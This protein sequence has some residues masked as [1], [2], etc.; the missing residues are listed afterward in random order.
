MFTVEDILSN[1][2][3]LYAR[4]AT[5]AA[6]NEAL[7]L[8]T[9]GFFVLCLALGQLFLKIG[10]AHSGVVVSTMT[11]TFTNFAMCGLAWWL[12]GFGLV[13]GSGSGFV[14]ASTKYFALSPGAG[15]SAHDT[16]GLYVW[17]IKMVITL[18]AC[19]A[20]AVGRVSWEA[21]IVVACVVST[22]G[23]IPVVHWVWGPDGWLSPIASGRLGSGLLDGGSSVVIHV[24]GGASAA[25]M[26][27]MVPSKLREV[28]HDKFSVGTGVILM[29]FGWY[30]LLLLSA[31]DTQ[32]VAHAIG[33]LTVGAGCACL[34]SL[35]LS[36][37][38]GWILRHT[39]RCT[40]AGLVS[41]TSAGLYCPM[42]YSLLIG[43]VGAVISTMGHKM[44]E[45]HYLFDPFDAVSSHLLAGIWGVVA[46]ALFVDEDLVK[47]NG[48]EWSGRGTVMGVHLLAVAAVA[49]WAVLWTFVGTKLAR[50]CLGPG[51]YRT[52]DYE[53]H[54]SVYC[55]M[56]CDAK[57][58]MD[59]KVG[60]EDVVSLAIPLPQRTPYLTLY[61]ALR[62]S[63]YLTFV[64]A[65]T[66]V[67]SAKY[68]PDAE[69]TSVPTNHT[70]EELSALLTDALNSVTM[71][72]CDISTLWMLQCSA[73]V[74]LMQMGFCFLEAGGVRS[75]SVISII[76]KNLVD[77]SLGALMWWMTGYAFA[78]G[79]GSGFIGGEEAM[80]ALSPKPADDLFKG[81]AH[82]FLSFT[83]MTASCTIVSGAVAERMNLYAYCLFV[84]VTCGFT[85]PVVVHWG[86]SST[87][88]LSAFSEDR[89]WGNGLLD[90][91]GSGVIHLF[92]G[93][94]AL[95]LAYLIGPR[96]L[97]DN[98]DLFSE[99]GQAIVSPHNKFLQAAGTLL[100]WISWFMFNGGSVVSFSNG[101]SAVAAQ[102]IVST[103]IA[104]CFAGVVGLL[105]SRYFCGFLDI[106]HACN[107]VLVG[108][109][110][111]TS[112]CAYVEIAFSPLIGAVGV[113][114]YFAIHKLRMRLRIDDVVDAGAVHF[115]GGLWGCIATGLFC[116]EEIMEAALER[117]VSG[118]GLFLGGGGTQ[119]GVQLLYCAVVMAWC[120]LWSL[121]VYF[122]CKYTIGA[123]AHIDAEMEGLDI[124]EHKAHSYDYIEKMEKERAIAVDSV[125]LA[126][127]IASSLVSFD[128]ESAEDAINCTDSPHLDA[129]CS[130]FSSLLSNL[131]SY[132]PYIPE[133]LFNNDTDSCDGDNEQQEV[134]PPG[135]G[136]EGKAAIVFTD[137]KG[138]TAS[139]EACPTDMRE[140]LRVH[141][142][143]IRKCI[144]TH[145]G[146]EVKTIGDA[147]M[148]A[149][150]QLADAARF[151]LDVQTGLHSYTKWPSGLES[152]PHCCV[153]SWYGLLV[154]IGMNYG[155]VHSEVNPITGRCDYSGPTVNKASRLEA[156]SEG[157]AVALPKEITTLLEASNV[158][159]SKV[160]IANKK[161][162][163]M[164]GVPGVHKIC[165]VTPVAILSQ[166]SRLGSDVSRSSCGSRQSSIG[167][168]RKQSHA[169]PSAV[170]QSKV[171]QQDMLK[172][173]QCTIG[174][175]W[176]AV[177]TTG[178]RTAEILIQ[179]SSV[180]SRICANMDRTEGCVH[181]V[182]ESRVAVTWN[183]GKRCHLHVQSGIRF[184][185]LCEEQFSSM[186]VALVNGT[187]LH[188]SVGTRD[189]RFVNLFGSAVAVSES[190]LTTA[191]EL[192]TFGL[193]GSMPGEALPTLDSSLA[194]FI[195]P[196]LRW[197]IPSEFNNFDSRQ[198][199]PNTEKHLC[200]YQ[201]MQGAGA[202]MLTLE[203]PGVPQSWQWS[204][205]YREAFYNDNVDVIRENCIDDPLSSVVLA[206]FGGDC[207]LRSVPFWAAVVPKR[208]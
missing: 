17:W 117:E 129:L 158:L 193:L 54:G 199:I 160:H 80:F 57:D 134:P 38:N 14:G 109:V 27:V 202:K 72:Q 141:N 45:K 5:V 8:G 6:D 165:I 127:Q 184:T 24:F 123:R 59:E 122:F 185:A 56:V 186:S 94:S 105:C 30:G 121:G 190:L 53:S 118:Y 119:L 175:V 163:V 12:Y 137:I 120:G 181:G 51:A 144:K 3:V 13:A 11:H 77:C 187:L 98:I 135:A 177:D 68:T 22:F 1:H 67:S 168:G 131:N 43:S 149:F 71:S 32:V 92:G 33:F 182:C 52:N 10:S 159:D 136:I 178:S 29:W 37:G 88:F 58:V 93:T 176:A 18:G 102:A 197:A 65:L 79:K 148:V 96:K 76:F 128:L 64:A 63:L 157:G 164:K 48:Y 139:W 28:S 170:T 150:E 108:L 145:N 66:A 74:F 99:E 206:A 207:E 124:H 189:Q 78:F 73:C 143:I 82:F 126:E 107:S 34:T 7:R 110:S 106:G 20:G 15:S 203:D 198:Q 113:V 146:Y 39:A 201:I 40:V 111:I 42:A 9:S 4:A 60:A 21:Y 179:I 112:A 153:G 97:R 169:Q 196:I 41:C 192:G 91:A 25:T 147:F 171:S 183:V 151:C 31:D 155:E 174:Q 49:V 70:L 84:V 138:S 36:E 194:P 195:R 50:Q 208:L 116:N 140:A 114:F 191:R 125:V 180:L 69:E 95:C 204:A 104:S 86:W 152:L 115:G 162:V 35:A 62:L 26:L 173:V 133:S 87:G 89:I 172:P 16:M 154:R 47:R 83:Y 188:G 19:S 81:L 156:A 46:T 61:T 200:I 132:R 44:C 55:D 205:S 101:G 23:F 100:L 2:S 75:V 130:A 90:F 167:G 85:Y 161:D 103:C 166:R 142:R